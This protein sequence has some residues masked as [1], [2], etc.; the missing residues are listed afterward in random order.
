MWVDKACMNH[1]TPLNQGSEQG[2]IRRGWGLLQ[3]IVVHLRRVLGEA[4][5]AWVRVVEWYQE[6][7]PWR[8]WS[9]ALHWQWKCCFEW[10]HRLNKRRVTFWVLEVKDGVII[11]EEVDFINGKRLSS[12]LLDNALDSLIISSLYKKWVTA[13]LLT[14][15]T[16]LRWDPFP[17]VRASPTLF[18]N[19]SM[20]AWI[21]SWVSSIDGYHNQI[22]Y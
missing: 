1:F 2:W 22:K 16:F 3:L 19:F 18:L 8:S 13:V 9:Q 7:G 10:K 12:N 4:C 14:T 5:A 15:L 11:S 6:V 17:P 21:Y 20:L